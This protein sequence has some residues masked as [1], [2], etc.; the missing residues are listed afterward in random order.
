MTRSDWLS[1]T[2][3]ISLGG[4]EFL[5]QSQIPTAFWSQ[6]CTRWPL[7]G[8]IPFVFVLPPFGL[9]DSHLEFL[10]PFVG[11]AFPHL[12]ITC[13]LSVPRGRS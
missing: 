3:L 7:K 13:F 8:E 9:P 5:A 2:S 4:G 11:V 1:T 10:E 12:V 6:P